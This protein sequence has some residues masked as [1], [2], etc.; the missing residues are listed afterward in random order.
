MLRAG[1]IRGKA[2][3]CA[4]ELWWWWLWW[5]HVGVRDGSCFLCPYLCTAVTLEGSSGYQQPSSYDLM[6]ETHFVIM[7]PTAFCLPHCH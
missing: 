1:L 2:V 5:Y 3:L 4:R 7:D 6:L